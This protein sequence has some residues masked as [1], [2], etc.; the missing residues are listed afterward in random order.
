MH[1]LFSFGSRRSFIRRFTFISLFIFLAVGCG[2]SGG[3]SGGGS[4]SGPAQLSVVN[5]QS[6]VTP[7]KVV[8]LDTVD[9]Y[10]GRATYPGTIGSR[11]ITLTVQADGTLIFIVPQG[12]SGKNT[13]ILSYKLPAHLAGHGWIGKSCLLVTP[14]YGPRV[15][16]SA[17]LTDAPLSTGTPM[18]QQ[19]GDCT[20][21]VDACPVRAFTGRPFQADEPRE[22]RFD[23]IK[24][25][26]FRG[27][28]TKIG[29]S[30]K[31]ERRSIYACGVCVKV[32]PVGK[33]R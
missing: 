27:T 10:P 8:A 28:D 3:G 22:A 5:N 33:D 18:A 14:E 6:T 26:I 21:C 11:A 25:E 13:S 15:R 24:C 19:C 20:V 7:L 16:F 12:L 1:T 30:Q 4:D 23:P 29:A 2:G 9:L 32:C 31:K 17:V